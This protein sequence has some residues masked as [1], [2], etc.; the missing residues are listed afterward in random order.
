MVQLYSHHRSRQLLRMGADA[1]SSPGIGTPQ[2][3]PQ[4]FQI[5]GSWQLHVLNVLLFRYSQDAFT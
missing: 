3:Q 2:A 4:H 5:A 1:S